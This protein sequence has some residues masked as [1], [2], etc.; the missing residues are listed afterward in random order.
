MPD[1]QES[2][3]IA[4]N[5][6]N[7]IDSQEASDLRNE[8]IDRVND[9]GINTRAD[10][11]AF[12]TEQQAEAK[13]ILAEKAKVYFSGTNGELSPTGKKILKESQDLIDITVK[14]LD[15]LNSASIRVACSKLSDIVGF[16]LQ[17]D[18]RSIDQFGLRRRYSTVENKK[19]EGFLN[20]EGEKMAASKMGVYGVMEET[21]RIREMEQHDVSEK[22]IL[23]AVSVL[24]KHGSV[25][26][27][28]LAKKGPVLV[29]LPEMHY[30]AGILRNNFDALMELKK[31][32]S[33]VGFEGAEGEVRQGADM[34]KKSASDYREDIKQGKILSSSQALEGA[35][36]EEVYTLGLENTH[37]LQYVGKKLALMFQEM[38]QNP[39]KREQMQAELRQLSSRKI[40][41]RDLIRLMDASMDEAMK[42][43]LVHLRDQL[44]LGRLQD[45]Y[46]G[47]SGKFSSPS[48]M[49]FLVCGS[50]HA[51]D[52]ANRAGH[53]GYRGVIT[54]S[55]KALNDTFDVK[56]L[57]MYMEAQF[58]VKL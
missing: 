37:T 20:Y 18:E 58:G 36:G 56:T 29:L 39:E 1:S 14:S 9:Q 38:M 41:K 24:K 11:F 49:T 33:L 51:K 23:E 6:K 7:V 34:P 5:R 52:L 44:W 47:E 55:P 42:D 4:V 25:T 30:D 2:Q 32:I 50:A 19:T 27:Q 54:F 35:L 57:R 28:S 31:M 48:N 3:I 13:N 43:M 8:T 12:I 10:L 40:T 46:L 22:D 16:A 53:Y 45:A 21:I 17:I 26:Y 15:G